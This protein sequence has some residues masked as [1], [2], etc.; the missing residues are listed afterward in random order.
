MKKTVF[1]L[2]I[3]MLVAFPV[4]VYANTRTSG[5]GDMPFY[6]RIERGEILHTD[7]WAVIIFYRSPGC[8]PADFNILDFFDFGAFGC[9]PPTTDGLVIWEGEPWLTAPIQIKLHGLGAVPVWFVSWSE[10]ETAVGDDELTINELAEL[11]SLLVGTADFYTETL[12]PTGGAKVPMI[13][14]VA[15]GYLENGTP[16]NVHALLV[17]DTANPAIDKNTSVQITFK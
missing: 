1:A 14:Y 16:F 11:P 7:E 3:L 13:N 6:A 10:L 4:T 17:A 15:L 9:T 12:H 8:V 5:G 2:V